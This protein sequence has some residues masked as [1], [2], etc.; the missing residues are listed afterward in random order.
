[1]V[2]FAWLNIPLETGFVDTCTIPTAG[3]AFTFQETAV[4][5]GGIGPNL[6]KVGKATEKQDVS[7]GIRFGTDWEL[8]E[9]PISTKLSQPTP[10]R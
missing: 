10:K 7:R 8:W 2:V 4:S 6:G 9:F 5:E 3:G 1:M